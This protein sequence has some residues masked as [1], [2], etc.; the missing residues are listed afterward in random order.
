MKDREKKQ[1]LPIVSWIS[2]GDAAQFIFRY[3]KLLSL[4]AVLIFFT[5]LITWGA[6]SFSLEF[7]DG[8]T[9]GFFNTSPEAV[10][11]WQRPL[12]WGWQV[13]HWLYIVMSRVI[14]FYLSF[15]VAYC[16]TSPGYVFLSMLAGNRFSPNV[17]A[18]EASFT[19]SGIIIDIWEGIK[20][21][22]VGVVA[23]LLALAVNFLPVIGQVAAFLIYVFY[24]TLMFI[25]F[26]S[27]RYRWNLRQKIGWVVS[28]KE[29]S[30]RLGLF[31]ALISLV[32]ILNIFF[33][34]LLFPLFTVHTTLN[35]L[36]IEKR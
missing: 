35:Y 25:D 28:H 5:G 9:S 13:I 19:L 12:V 27:S 29:T 33:L 8:L 11:F 20:I 26:P 4:S 32:P 23:S 2:L 1:R 16:I 6:M 24:S 31:P 17:A 21:G 7:I 36:I 14:V 15:L 22:M 18:G 10:H 30:F 3:P 34:A